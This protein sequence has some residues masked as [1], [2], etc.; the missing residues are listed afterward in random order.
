MSATTQQLYSPH[1]WGYLKR[2]ISKK[3]GGAKATLPGAIAALNTHKPEGFGVTVKESAEARQT[4]SGLTVMYVV[5][6]CDG[7]DHALCLTIQELHTLCGSA[8]GSFAPSIKPF[9]LKPK[10]Q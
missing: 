10:Q 4:Q 7:K 2:V 1:M 8:N 6:A 5:L 9:M 3:A